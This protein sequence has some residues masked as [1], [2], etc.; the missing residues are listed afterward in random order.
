MIERSFHEKQTSSD[1]FSTIKIIAKMEIAREAMLT[2]N[3]TASSDIF[4]K[5]MHK[6]EDRVHILS[7]QLNLINKEI[8]I[9]LDKLNDNLV[10]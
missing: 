6:I 5:L 10:S 2:S 9:D 3:M 4:E 7:E 1:K 8:V